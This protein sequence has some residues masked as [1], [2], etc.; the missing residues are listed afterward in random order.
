MKI[1][2]GSIAVTLL[3]GLSSLTVHAANPRTNEKAAA[4]QAVRTPV[5]TGV[6]ARATVPGQ[7]V[8]GAYMKISSPIDVTLLHVET[9][10]AKEV[11][12]HTMHMDHGMM[13]MRE[14]GP[15]A[16]P[17]G[18]TIELAPGGLHLMLLGLKQALKAGDT[19]TL[20][21]TFIDANKAKTTSVIKAPVRPI[22]Q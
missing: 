16:I 7:P 19:M 13:R 2:M 12:V 20:K 14:H 11:Q 6:W 8:G 18:K 22:G 9:D 21:M 10:V 3:V 15:L 17:A 1:A 5:I 4:A